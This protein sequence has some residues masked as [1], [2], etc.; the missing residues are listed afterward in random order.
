MRV[1]YLALPAA[2]V[3]AGGL[4]A[5]RLRTTYAITP[6]ANWSRLS[7]SAGC[8]PTSTSIG[9]SDFLPP[10]CFVVSGANGAPAALVTRGSPGA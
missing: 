1:A 7:P 10:D 2:P 9:T 5:A 4:V 8:S 6:P 3:L